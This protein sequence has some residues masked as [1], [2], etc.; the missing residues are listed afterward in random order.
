MD[1]LAW[2][3]LANGNEDASSLE[4]RGATVKGL[5]LMARGAKECEEARGR[6]RTVS[7]LVYATL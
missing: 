7:S 4:R 1:I 3:C 5:N 2:R 6:Y